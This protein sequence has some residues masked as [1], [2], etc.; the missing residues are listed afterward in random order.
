MK[1][2]ICNSLAAEIVKKN[3][4]HFPKTELKNNSI[5]AIHDAIVQKF[6]EKTTKFPT[7]TK[8]AEICTEEKL[9]K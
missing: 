2:A 3:E 1:R 6:K 7:K 9:V 4:I 5:L 8:H